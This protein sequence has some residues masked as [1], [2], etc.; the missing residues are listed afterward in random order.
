LTRT[1]HWSSPAGRAVQITATR[2]V[3]FTHRAVTAIR[4]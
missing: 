2:L 1:V 3:S 4:Y